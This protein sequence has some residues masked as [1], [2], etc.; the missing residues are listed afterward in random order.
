M[1][2][3][4]ATVSALRQHR[5]RQDDQGDLAGPAW[6]DGFTD[7]QGLSRHALVWAYGDGSP[8]HPKTFYE[9]FLR[10]SAEA[11]LPRIRLHDVRHSYAS[12]AL[13]AATGWHDVKVISQ[14]LG[15]ASV[16]ITLDTYSHVLP[17]ADSTLANTLASVILGRR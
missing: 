3:D 7:W 9:R 11:G 13:A 1:A 17:A 2:L 10:L 12:A 14:R 6:R 16:S 4:P 5:R 8:V 15:H